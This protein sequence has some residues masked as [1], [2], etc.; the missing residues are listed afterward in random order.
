MATTRK[1]SG[2]KKPPR[3]KPVPAKPV[4]VKRLEVVVGDITTLDVDI[5]VNAA[6]TELQPGGG[7]CGAIHHAAGPDL[8]DA[9]EAIGGCPTGAAVLTSGFKLPALHVVHAVGPVWAGGNHGEPE[10]LA[11]AYRNSLQLAQRAQAKSV[12]FPA[13]STGIYGYPADAAASI[14]VTAVRLHLRENAYPQRVIL[15]AFDEAARAQLQAAVDASNE[16]DGPVGDGTGQFEVVAGVDFQ[17]APKPYTVPPGK[18]LVLRTCKADMR[19]PSSDAK[20]FVWP[21]S[22]PVECPDWRPDAECGH[23]LHGALWGEG[24]GG[25]PWCWEADANW[26]VVEVDA[27]DVVSLDGGSKVKF[28]RGVVVFCGLRREATEWLAV[29]APGRK[30]IGALVAAGYMGTASAGYMGTASAGDMGTASAGYMG[31][32]SAGDMGTASA[33]DMG[34]ASAGYMGTASAGEAGCLTLRWHDGDRYRVAVFAVGEGEIIPNAFYRLDAKGKIH[35]VEKC[36]ARKH[37]H[38]DCKCPPVEAV[39]GESAA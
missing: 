17:A 37:P 7:V 4:A 22:G 21:R 30:I 8:A 16:V 11:S 5:I 6:N 2:A 38:D 9:C 36:K 35:V 13:I 12:A 29:R 18:A 26:L 14:A 23:G 24:S 39:S 34:T 15:C 33:G 3:D 19:S 31:T 20:G 28:P 1:K 10:L 25:D 32:A 27:A